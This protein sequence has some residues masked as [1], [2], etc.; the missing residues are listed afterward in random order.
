M[1]KIARYDWTDPMLQE[2]VNKQIG[3]ISIPV[4]VNSSNLQGEFF[5]YNFDVMP[6]SMQKI[7]PETKYQK[8]LQ[9]ISQVILPTLQMAASQG[10]VLNAPELARR[11]AEYLDIDITNLYSMQQPQQMQP[12]AYQPMG[13]QSVRTSVSGQA[14]NRAGGNSANAQANLNTQQAEAY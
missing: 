3:N 1:K 6:Y 12:D 7:N 8:T 2:V 11:T 13:G 5:D 14:D 4:E 9:W 10:A